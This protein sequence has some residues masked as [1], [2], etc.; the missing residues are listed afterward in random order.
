MKYLLFISILLISQMN[1]ASDFT[2]LKMSTDSQQPESF[3]PAK[4]VI[5]RLIGDRVN[6]IRFHHIPAEDGL[7]SFEIVSKNGKLQ[8]GGSSTVAICY[9]FNTYLKDACNSMVTW[10]G[11]NLNIPVKWPEY[12]KKQSSPYKFRYYLNVCTFGYTTPYWDWSRWE[13]ELDWMALHGIN[14]P[15]ASVA[16]EAIAEKVWLKLGLKKNEIREFFTGPAH[17][18]WHRMGNLNSWDGPLSDTW[19]ENQLKLQHR[20]IDRMR[21]LGFDPIAPAFAGFVP[22]AFMEKHPELKFK[23]MKWGGFSERNNAFVLPPDSPL[24]EKIGAMFIQEWEKEFGK[25]TYYL[26]DSLMKWNCRFPK[27]TKKENTNYSKGMVNRFTNR[28]LQVIPMLFG[29]HRAGH[30]DISINSGTN[31]AYRHSYGKYLTIE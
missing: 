31:R 30:S 8:I 21:E 9:G 22:E 14:M 27:M 16:S 18:P 28:S 19:Q 10:S 25:N 6:E 3:V 20:I 1:F 11:K 7:D 29:L 12:E 5:R 26:S 4:S 15:L 24:F 13:K 17:L 23:H 2:T